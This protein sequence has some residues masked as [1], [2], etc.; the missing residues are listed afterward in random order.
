MRSKMLFSLCLKGW[1]WRKENLYLYPYFSKMPVSPISQLLSHWLMSA[2]FLKMQH[3]R[4]LFCLRK[5]SARELMPI[6]QTSA[7][8]SATPLSKKVLE[9]DN[10]WNIDNVL[11]GL[12]ASVRNTRGYLVPLGCVYAKSFVC[13]MPRWELEVRISTQARD[14]PNQVCR[15]MPGSGQNPT[16]SGLGDAWYFLL[17]SQLILNV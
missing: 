15:M 5:I 1:C 4:A 2:H 14:R 6:F 3:F 16:S 9:S 8:Q 7:T 13:D 17:C 10:R 11:S 12:H